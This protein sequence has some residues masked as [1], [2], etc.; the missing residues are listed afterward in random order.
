M[1]FSHQEKLINQSK[2]KINDKKEI[3]IFGSD[4]IFQDEV[5]NQKN[6]EAQKIKLRKSKL[7]KKVKTQE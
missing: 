1:L 6:L 5:V 3:N 2:N 7:V 4:L